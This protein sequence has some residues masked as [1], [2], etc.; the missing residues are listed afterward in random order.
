MCV[1]TH[2]LQEP[3]VELQWLNISFK[4]CK[5]TLTPTNSDVFWDQVSH[6]LPGRWGE[7][8][9][10]CSLRPTARTPGLQQS[11]VA[12]LGAQTKRLTGEP[13]APCQPFLSFFSQSRGQ[14]ALFLFSQ[15]T[16]GSMAM[17]PRQCGNRHKRSGLFLHSST[18]LTSA[19]SYCFN[20]IFMHSPMHLYFPDS[21]LN[22]LI[23]LLIRSMF[24]VNEVP[25]MNSLWEKTFLR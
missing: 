10:I 3:K 14:C 9:H 24:S 12:Y 7:I 19:I 16:G 18:F 2:S 20:L 21:F 22:L 13:G 4:Y 15:G 6:M 8:F 11:S 5:H 23:L 1:A 17:F 25:Q